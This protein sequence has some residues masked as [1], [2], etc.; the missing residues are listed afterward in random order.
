MKKATILTCLALGLAT[1]IPVPHLAANAA[2]QRVLTTPS[3]GSTGVLS[4]T[5]PFTCTYST[6]GSDVFPVPTGVSQIAV[7]VVGAQGGFYFIAGDAAHGGSPAGDLTGRPG[8]DGGEAAGTLTGLTAGQILQVDIAGI[9]VNGTAASRSGGMMNGPSGGS[10]ALG[11]F[12]GSN[13]GVSGGAGDAAGANG[14]T[15]FDGGN[16]P[17]GGGSS[18]VRV[19]ANGCAGLTCP[20]TD[21]VLVGA[22]G[23]GGGGTGGQG[24]ALGGAGGAGG[25]VPTLAVDDPTAIPPVYGGAGSIA[26][27]GGNAGMSGTGGTPSAGGTGGLNACRHSTDGPPNDPADPLT[28]PRCGGDGAIGASGLGGAGGAGNL[29]CTGTLVPACSGGQNATSSGGGAGGGAGGGWF[30]GGGGSG[31]GGMF[32]GGGGAGGGAGGGSSFAAANVTSPV[33]TAGMNSPTAPVNNGNGQ[34]VVTWTAGSVAS[35]TT[36]T[37]N[38]TPTSP[39]AAGTPET[40]T[41]TVSPAAAAGSVQFMDGA[42]A[43]GGPVTVNSGPASTTLTLGSGS[44]SLTAVFTPSS[45]TA[46]S[47]STSA[48][49]SYTVNSPVVPT[50]TQTTLTVTPPSPVAAGTVETL[51][52]SVSAVTAPGSIQFLD[53]TTAVGGPIA[54]AAGAAETTTTLAPGTHSITAVFTP[55]NSVAFTGSTSAAA[56][57]TVNPASQISSTGPTGSGPAPGDRHHHGHGSDNAPSGCRTG[58]CTDIVTGLRPAAAVEN[59]GRRSPAPVR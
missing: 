8:G 43:L 23:G 2:V 14:G 32:G 29:P 44:H 59:S 49:T 11:G 47:G 21:R 7:T 33:L 36:T 26:V 52:A 20:L 54:V 53:G 9:G 12:G 48:A 46:F 39:A 58:G 57:Y 35:S 18:D 30:G 34:I 31:G 19:D 41:A 27:D 45:P 22:G 56:S 6:V 38:V 13:H 50:P 16:G 5:G 51:T 4:G 15:A 55:T 10:G 1:A 28:D 24:N 17:G 25:G 42:A 37:L 3:C 40:L